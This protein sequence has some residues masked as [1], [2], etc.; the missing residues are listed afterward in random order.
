MPMTLLNTW[1]LWIHLVSLWSKD[2]LLLIFNLQVEYI[3]LSFFIVA[4]CCS[5]TLNSCSDPLLGAK[6]TI[7][8]HWWTTAE[9]MLV[10]DPFPR[11]F[12]LCSRLYFSRTNTPQKHII[13][14]FRVAMTSTSLLRHYGRK[15]ALLDDGGKMLSVKWK[16][17]QASDKS[18]D[19]HDTRTQR[20]MECLLLL[21]YTLSL[22]Q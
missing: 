6:S 4:Y 11:P 21:Q 20:R 13:F 15:T 17:S 3:S 8:V 12:S 19:T 2:Y 22:C 9:L 14:A 10:S 7:R 18:V 5:L 1:A 16:M